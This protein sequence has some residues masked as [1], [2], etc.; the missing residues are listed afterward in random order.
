[1]RWNIVGTTVMG[2]AMALALA[3][4][5]DAA[6]NTGP[7]EAEDTTEAAP[8]EAEEPAEEETPEPEAT[9]EPE[10]VEEPSTI[11][12][13]PTGIRIDGANEATLTFGQRQ[14]AV[15]TAVRALLGSPEM[16]SNEE[17]GAGPIQFATFDDL[18]LNFQNG[19]FA[20]WGATGDGDDVLIS[21]RNGLKIG[22]RKAAVSEI[23]GYEPFEDSTLG[24]EFN[25]VTS[26]EAMVVGM[27][28]DNGR[29]TDLWTGA[30]CTFR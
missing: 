22:A 23:A 20:G 25:I 6:D 10:V 15:V 13:L 27:F 7:A 29:V 28:G 19:E 2:G 14:D 9:T 8:A 17:C 21:A 26:E 1:M 16:G 18:Q 3:A 12:L 5:G 30:V 11:T 24:D 4:C